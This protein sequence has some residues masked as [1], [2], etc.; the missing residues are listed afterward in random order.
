[1]SDL[2]PH[3]FN[4]GDVS[5]HRH[6]LSWTPDELRALRSAL[7]INATL[8]TPTG[9]TTIVPDAAATAGTVGSN[10]A[11]GDHT[12]GIAAVAPA[13]L[14]R[15][16]TAAEGTGNDFAR[17]THVHSTDAIGW[18][19]M[20]PEFHANSS[21]ADS[22]IALTAGTNVVTD[23]TATVTVDNTRSYELWLILQF[24]VAA[25]G[26]CNLNAFE[27]A[28]RFARWRLFK[29]RV[30]NDQDSVC[31]AVRY[32]PATSGSFALNLRVDGP[33]GNF[34]LQDTTDLPR[35]LYLKDIGPRA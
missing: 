19:K 30:V 15:T 17:A 35:R 23:M 33:T 20:L 12:H 13:G 1:M 24:L 9:I 34:T 14:T 16:A 8:G 27:G 4:I 25:T 18:G 26:N 11:Y 22:V 10:R 3:P 2:T 29:A 6:P 28:T 21:G 5:E 31:G 7:D 32:E